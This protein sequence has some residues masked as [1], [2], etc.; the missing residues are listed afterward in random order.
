[1]NWREICFDDK[2]G[3]VGILVPDVDHPFFSSYVRQT[4]A[5][6]YELGIRL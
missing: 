6:L 4:E 1:M 3:I 5:A 2:T